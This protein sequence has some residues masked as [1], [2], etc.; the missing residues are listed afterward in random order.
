MMPAKTS[1]LSKNIDKLAFLSRLI[2]GELEIF[3]LD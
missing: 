3:L 2:Y 1:G